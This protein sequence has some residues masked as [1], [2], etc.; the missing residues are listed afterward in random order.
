MNLTIKNIPE[1]VYREFKQAAAAQG[2]S[3][4][5]QLIQALAMEAA[6]LERRRQMKSSRK[7]LERFVTS[8]PKMKTESWRLLGRERERRD[9]R[10]RS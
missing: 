1:N 7:E 5:A 10:G 2:R 4:N 6:E 3:L 8:L 9:E